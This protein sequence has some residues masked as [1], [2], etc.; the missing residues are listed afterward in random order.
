MRGERQPGEYRQ[1]GQ[2]CQ[3]ARD[4]IRRE[5]EAMLKSEQ[6]SKTPRKQR[7]TAA[8][9]HRLLERQ[10]LTVSSVTVRRLVA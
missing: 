10:G 2:R 9:I 7:L 1:S 5:V 8:R 6:S 3:P 4:K